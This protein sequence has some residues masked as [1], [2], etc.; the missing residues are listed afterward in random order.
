MMPRFAAR[1][2][3]CALALALVVSACA[4]ETIVPGTP[5]EVTEKK[6]N[7]FEAHEECLRLIPGDWLVYQFT[8]QRP[9]DFNIHYRDGKM[10]IMP[11]ARDKAMEGDETFRP[12]V[13]QDYC[14]TWQAGREG[15]IIDYRIL[16]N[17][18]Q[19]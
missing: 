17:R 12:L 18:S 1:S 6:I 10:V 16:L 19:R 7:P 14:L 3:D 9:V 4:S 15:A 11:L 13:A 5:R 8:A 2:A